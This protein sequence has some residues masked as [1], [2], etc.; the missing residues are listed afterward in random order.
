MDNIGSGDGL[1]SCD[2]SLPGMMMT[3]L[4]D[5]LTQWGRVTHI[6]VGILTIIGSDNFLSPGRHQAITWANAVILLTGPLGTT[7][8]SEI[9]IEIRIFSFKKMYLKMSSAKWR[10]FCLGI[11]LLIR[12]QRILCADWSL[13]MAMKS[14][15]NNS[16][17]NSNSIILIWTNMYMAFSRADLEGGAPGARPP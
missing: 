4:Y 8:F 5:V 12:P 10:P 7:N 2:K 13:Q 14:Q 3:N 15:N 11:N 1:M 16:K 17:S 9:L 6:C